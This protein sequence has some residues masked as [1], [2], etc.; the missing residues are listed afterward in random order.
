M[1]RKE[2][3]IHIGTEFEVAH[4]HP[5]DATT[6]VQIGQFHLDLAVETAR[7]KQCT[8]ED[9]GTVGCRHDDDA[10]VG[11]ETVHLCKQL[12]QRTF[13]FI[14]GIREGSLATSAANRVNL[15][16]EDDAGGFLLGGAEKVAH[17]GGTHAHEHLHEIR[18]RQ[19]EERHLCLACHSLG[20]Q[21]LTRTRRADQQHAFGDLA[22]QNGIFLRVLEEIDDLLNLEL[23]TFQTGNIFKSHQLSVLLVKF[24]GAG[25]AD[26]EDAA[27]TANT[28]AS[29]THGAYREKVKQENQ[30]N[31]QQPKD[32]LESITLRIVLLHRK[33][34]L[35]GYLTGHQGA[36]L[37]NAFLHKLRLGILQ[38]FV[39]NL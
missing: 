16:D 25:L 11:T 28:A 38:I 17:A 23:R 1:F 2:L 26:I 33:I 7:A 22:T 21:G 34:V 30:K 36:V 6:L 20:Q 10:R 31:R 24:L 29:A 37:R 8:V 3:Q 32:N 9:V 4:V 13:T 14:V 5:E 19:G 12:V 27:S 35:F 18:T 39:I 15:I